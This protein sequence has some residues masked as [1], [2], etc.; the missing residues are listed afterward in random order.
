MPE[1]ARPA[2]AGP[3]L[4]AQPAPLPS[5]PVPVGQF[6]QILSAVMLPMFLSAADQTLLATATPSIAS[7]LGNLRDTTWISVGYLIAMTATVPLYGRLGDR[8][9]RRETLL[10]A[11]G[12][13]GAGSLACALAGSLG[14]LVAA[15]VLQGLGGGGLMVMSQSLIGELVP[16]RERARFQG[17]FAAIFTLANVGGPLIGGLVVHRASWRWLFLANLPLGAIALW[18]L[19][20]LPRGAPNRGATPADP[21]GAIVFAAAVAASLIWATFAG[22]RFAWTSATSAA[23]A[24]GSVLLWGAL[25][26]RE[27][28][29]ATPFLP[30][31]LLRD[32]SMRYLSLTV[33]SFSSCLFALIFFLPVL[34]QMGH[35][36]DAQRAGVLLLPLMLGIVAG[37]TITGRIVSRTGRPTVMPMAGMSLSCAAL[38]LMALLPAHGELVAALGALCGFGFGGVAPTSQIISQVLAGRERLGAA[39]SVVSLSRYTGAALGTAIFGAFVFAL[40]PT[41]GGRFDPH[42]LA[43]TASAQLTH[44]IRSGFVVL[45]AVAAVGAW[46]A[47]RMQKIRL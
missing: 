9:G 32:R 8:F 28:V 38:L 35:G 46:F 3:D 17:Y 4:A 31:E 37:S 6:L 11:L 26:R 22:Y 14:A 10:A 29:L 16:P 36:A 40:A 41:G 18:R 47:S 24:A 43:A 30:I 15:R 20:R 19:L 5:Q 27:F 23:L 12:L 7:D 1:R 25:I 2:E 21:L 34:L 45:A 39:A 33:V 42:N 44:A 13:F